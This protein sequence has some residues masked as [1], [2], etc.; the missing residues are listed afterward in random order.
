M[1]MSKDL[2]KENMCWLFI[3][4]LSVCVKQ[5]FEVGSEEKFALESPVGTI[6]PRDFQPPE[7]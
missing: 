5:D 3:L 7:N 4:I 6:L 1:A 2:K